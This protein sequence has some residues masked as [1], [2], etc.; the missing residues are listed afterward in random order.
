MKLAS[1]WFKIAILVQC[2][3]I[4]NTV[5]I[6]FFLSAKLKVFEIAGQKLLTIAFIGPIITFVF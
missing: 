1:I 4:G 6:R 5:F 3:C 2:E